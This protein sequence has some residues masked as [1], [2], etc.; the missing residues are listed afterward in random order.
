MDNKDPRTVCYYYSDTWVVRAQVKLVHGGLLKFVTGRTLVISNIQNNGDPTIEEGR[1]YN[2]TLSISPEGPLMRIAW[3]HRLSIWG[4]G[5]AYSAVAITST[6]QHAAVHFE[7]PWV[8]GA[9]T[10]VALVDLRMVNNMY[11]RLIGANANA[12]LNWWRC[13]C[14][15]VRMYVLVCMCVVIESTANTVVYYCYL[16]YIELLLYYAG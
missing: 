13:V 15:Y 6:W 2:L 10:H 7:A 3:P 14:M 4:G 8:V 11:D 9:G 5:S 1:R 12:R 16:N